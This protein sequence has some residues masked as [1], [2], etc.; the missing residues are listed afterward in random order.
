M[1]VRSVLRDVG[2]GRFGFGSLLL[3]RG[4]LHVQ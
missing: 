1:L 3:F 4:K 2:V